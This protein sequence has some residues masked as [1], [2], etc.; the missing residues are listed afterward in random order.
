MGNTMSQSAIRSAVA[1]VCAILLLLGAEPK[2]FAQAGSTGGT[3][4]NTD[5]SISGDRKEAPQESGHQHKTKPA[6]RA[7]VPA[8]PAGGPKT[9]QDPR[10]NGAHVNWCMTAQLGGCGQGAANAWCESKGFSHATSFNW[11][12]KSP[13]ISQGDHVLCDGFCGSFTY[14][15][16]E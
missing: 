12:V 9:F 10:I 7:D 15:T 5:K 3:L 11:V 2:A 16:C 6:A 8:K 14:V 13:A 4:G 1:G